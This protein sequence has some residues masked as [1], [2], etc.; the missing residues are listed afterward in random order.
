MGLI[1]DGIRRWSRANGVTLAEAYHRGSEKVT[2][3]LLQL[4]ECGVR[5]I[6]VYNLSRANLGRS[7]E[8]LNPVFDASVHFLTT[9]VPANFDP[10]TCGVRVHGDLSLVREDLRVAA[11]DIESSMR[12]EDFRINLLVA[13]DAVDE[14]REAHRRAVRDGC[15]IGEAF[16]IGEVHLVLRTSPEPLLSG[17]LPIQSQYAQLRFL[18]T[19]LMELDRSQIS[20][21]LAEYHE[22]P[23][24]RG[25]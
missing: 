12:G 14:L 15:D 5:T 22:F 9:L 3:I 6:S 11:R 4:Q 25:R 18:S 20:A 2:E 16:D 17:F 8:E 13:Y 21:L 1:P 7:P 24:L 23:Q 19:P 10:A